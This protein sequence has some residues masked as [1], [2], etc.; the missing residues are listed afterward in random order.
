MFVKKPPVIIKI[1]NAFTKMKYN[2]IHINKYIKKKYILAEVINKII[3]TYMY[4][5][6]IS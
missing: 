2:D 6:K 3:N 1:F 5:A 4:V